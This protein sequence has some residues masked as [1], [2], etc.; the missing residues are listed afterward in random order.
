MRHAFHDNP[1][2]PESREAMMALGQFFE[3]HLGK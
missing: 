1:T 3:T 2:L